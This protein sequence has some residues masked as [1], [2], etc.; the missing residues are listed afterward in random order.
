MHAE[1]VERCELRQMA[2][3]NQQLKDTKL[4]VRT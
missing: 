4:K 2:Q 3:G 1:Q